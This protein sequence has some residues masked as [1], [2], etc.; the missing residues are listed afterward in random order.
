MTVH[1]AEFTIDLPKTDRRSPL[2]WIFSHT[3][4]QWPIWLAAFIRAFGNAALAAVTPILT[5]QAVTAVL[6][7]PPLIEKLLPIAVT[8]GITQIVRGGLQLARNFGFEVIAQRMERDTR[9]EL[10]ASLLGRA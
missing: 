3:V 4:R 10:Y 2:R 6:H 1:S 7:T 9:K 5:G 8:I